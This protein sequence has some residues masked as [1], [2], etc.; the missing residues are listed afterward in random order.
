MA[1]S[2]PFTIKYV[3]LRDGSAKTLFFDDKTDDTTNLDAYRFTA[4]RAGTVPFVDFHLTD[5]GAVVP[6]NDDRINKTAQ[7]F[8]FARGSPPTNE[9]ELL[10]LRELRE[11][12]AALVAQR[13]QIDK[14]IALIADDI[15]A[16]EPKIPGIAGGR[17][18]FI[19]S[20]FCK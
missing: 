17:R 10:R 9:R 7:S 3:R 5:R 13:T 14:R 18:Q 20:K 1:Y 12:M 8:S 15:A 6:F 2:F 11:E 4:E 19:Y 16:L